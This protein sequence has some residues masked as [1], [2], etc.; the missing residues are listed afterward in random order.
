MW[1]LK[2]R[3]IVVDRLFPYHFN[4]FNN[5]GPNSQAAFSSLLVRNFS[6]NYNSLAASKGY[7]KTTFNLSPNG[8]Y[9]NIKIVIFISCLGYFGAVETGKPYPPV[10]NMSY[11]IINS[12]HISFDTVLGTKGT[13]N[14]T[15]WHFNLIVY[16]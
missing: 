14:K 4:L 11:H 2:V 10:V 9:D 5:F 3:Y 7:S 8:N 6:S 15:R 16:D 12:T 13:I 1:E